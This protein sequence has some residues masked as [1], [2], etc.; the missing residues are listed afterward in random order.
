[1][2]Y[3]RMG[4]GNLCCNDY[5]DPVFGRSVETFV[6]LNLTSKRELKHREITVLGHDSS[7]S[8][9]IPDF[10]N[11]DIEGNLTRGIGYLFLGL[12]NLDYRI[13][14]ALN[15]YAQKSSPSSAAWAGE[16]RR[17]TETTTS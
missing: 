17:R 5:V 15:D 9:K 16:R 3:G 7:Y 4:Y 10:F 1:M 6:V 12:H 8:K 11:L 14:A 13:A 2:Y